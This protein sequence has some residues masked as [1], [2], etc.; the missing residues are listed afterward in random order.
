MTRRDMFNKIQKG[1][2]TGVKSAFTM[3]FNLVKNSDAYLDKAATKLES[4]EA[5]TRRAFLGL[6]K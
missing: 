1:A 5:I 6:K 4:Q 2:E 3:I